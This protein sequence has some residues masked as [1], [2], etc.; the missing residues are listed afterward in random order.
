[1]TSVGDRSTSW[2]LTIVGAVLFVG[3][4]AVLVPWNPVPGG[5]PDPASAGD[6]F[7]PEE[8]ARAEAFTDLQRILSWC[9]LGISTLVACWLGFT[10]AG[11]RLLG[12]RRPHWT[13]TVVALTAVVTLIGTLVNLP[14]ALVLRHR[15]VE[16]G[17]SL[18]GLGDWFIDL[19]K[20][21]GITLLVTSIA[22]LVLIGCARRWKT[23]WPVIAG[24]LCAVLIIGASYLYPVVVEPMFGSFESMPDGEMR[25]Q[26]LALADKEDVDVDDVLVSD[27]SARTTT[28][29]AYV[30]GF[31]GTRRVVVYDNLIASQP[32]DRVLSVVAHELAHAKHNDVVIGT[33][34]GALGALVGVGLLG[35]VMSGGPVRRRAGVEGMGDPKAVALIL[36]LVSLASLGVSPVQNSISRQ[37][38]MRADVDA[39]K[40]TDASAMVAL[41]KELCLRSLCDPSGPAWSQFWFGSHPTVLERVAV[42]Q[43]LR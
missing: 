24:T 33:G 1:M 36:A 16:A 30:S 25:S 41:Q 11:T 5:M 29:N 35:L 12:R 23:W 10:R 13:V 40:V 37:I 28:L 21:Y 31:G 4:A 38:E 6:V 34:L 3:V 22:L 7:T 18:Q 17:L 27:A 2:A 26:I 8:I 42:A 43:R 39:L 15:R 14:L 19:A 32:R 9:S 20:N